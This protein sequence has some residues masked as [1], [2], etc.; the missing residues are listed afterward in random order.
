MKQI[1]ETKQIPEAWFH[2]DITSV[3]YDM[4]QNCVNADETG[5]ICDALALRWKFLNC[6]NADEII[7]LYPYYL[8]DFY[9]NRK[10]LR[11]NLKN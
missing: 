5:F 9:E 7:G 2:S 4:R 11:R 3:A 10:F 1:W 8:G 6:V